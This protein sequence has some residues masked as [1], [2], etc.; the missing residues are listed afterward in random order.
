MTQETEAAALSDFAS[1]LADQTRAAMC[2]ALLD[3]R[4]WTAGEL[5]RHA[6]V[7]ASS[8]TEHLNK[9]IAAG[10]ATERRQGRHRYVMLAG[11]QMAELIES[12]SARLRPN[13]PRVTGLR[14]GTANEALAR[15]RTCYDHFAGRL[16]ITIADA[17]IDRYLIDIGGG[18]S[19]TTKGYD[20]FEVALEVDTAT[21]RQS[22]R[23][24]IR[25]CLDWTER[26]SHVAGVAGAEICRT[27]LK[28]GWVR[29]IG[30]GR[31]VRLTP[32]G[33]QAVSDLLGING[34]AAELN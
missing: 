13:T 30:S 33:R 16:G 24:L 23:D 15:G 28:H 32:S 8:A 4:A 12:L 3:G 14:A 31:A 29:R 7:A 6:G 11:P 22:R 21:W 34:D 5:A 19:L 10:I 1:L 18:F 25:E 20:W 9:L 17:M 26:R 2:L 27:F